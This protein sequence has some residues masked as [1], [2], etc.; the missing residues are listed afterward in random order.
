VLPA[1]RLLVKTENAEVGSIT[2]A[3]CVIAGA[4]VAKMES[5]LASSDRATV[6]VVVTGAVGSG[7]KDTD[8]VTVTEDP[9]IPL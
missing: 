6:R 7:V 4:A 5:T 3:A 1:R 9:R 8:K 2:M